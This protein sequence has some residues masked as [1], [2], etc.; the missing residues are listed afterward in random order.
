MA[1]ATPANPPLAGTK[2][3][4]PT[5]VH[6]PLPDRLAQHSGKPGSKMVPYT[7]ANGQ[8]APGY[9]PTRSPNTQVGRTTPAGPQWGGEAGPSGNDFT[10][11]EPGITDTP[12]GTPVDRT[13]VFSSP[14]GDQYP[15][16]THAPAVDYTRGVG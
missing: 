16:D 1:E 14:K 12:A 11:N 6:A 8:L 5:D 13:N 2:N 9:T 7:Y 4:A 15:R 10:Q 3:Y